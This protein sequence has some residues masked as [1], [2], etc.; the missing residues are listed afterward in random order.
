MSKLRLSN[1]RMGKQRRLKNLPRESSLKNLSRLLTLLLQSLLLR[2]MRKVLRLMTRA[3]TTTSFFSVISL[4]LLIKR[5]RTKQRNLA[6]L[7]S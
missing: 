4:N 6:S 1:P 7:K 2:K 3:K 5:Q